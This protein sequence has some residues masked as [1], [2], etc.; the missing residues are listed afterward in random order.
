VEDNELNTEIAEELLT[1]IGVEVETAAN[2]RMAVERVT[3][4]PENYYDL[5]FM[6][7]QMPEMNGYEAATA[8]RKNGREDLKTIP[9]V[10][11]TADAFTDDVQRA[12]DVG[13][14]GHL[15]KPVQLEKLYEALDKWI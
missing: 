3:Q 8:I 10:A 12:K 11:M 5:I 6:D 15:A 2:G 7:I 14:T 13:M 1:H 4:T 9:I